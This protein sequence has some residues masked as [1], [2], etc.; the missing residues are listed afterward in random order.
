MRSALTTSRTFGNWSRRSSGILTPGRLV[1][2]VLLVAE[3]RAGQ[4]E[5][6]G[7]VVGLEVLDAAQDDAREAEDAVDQLA[8]G[9]R[10]RRQGE[11]S[12]VDEPVAVEQHQAFHRHGLGAGPSDGPSVPRAG[13]GPVSRRR[14]RRAVQRRPNS[15]SR[16]RGAATPDERA[17]A[18]SPSEAAATAAAAMVASLAGLVG[19]AAHRASRRSP[20]L[21]RVS[22]RRR[23]LP[24]RLRARRPAAT[25]CA[26]IRRGRR[27]ALARPAAAAGGAPRI[28]G[29]L[30]AR[31]STVP[32]AAAL[33]GGVRRRA[34]AVAVLAVTGGPDWCEGRTAAAAPDRATARSRPAGRRAR[35]SSGRPRAAG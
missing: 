33:G 22:G 6:D 30:L 19:Q 28:G 1:L 21:R 3:G 25:G 8:L 13:D 32:S 24:R 7:Q 15:A 31:A 17:S 2:G 14:G 20:S 26:A 29:S 10:Q 9:R 5:R 11:V 35:A 34:L 18:P 4:V 27:T 16:R 23:G 12:A